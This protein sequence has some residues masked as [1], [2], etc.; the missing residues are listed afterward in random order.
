MNVEQQKEFI[1]K[2]LKSRPATIAELAKELGVSDDTIRNRMKMMIE[3]GR[4]IRVVDWR[5]LNTA[6]ARVFG[7]G[8]GPDAP[9]PVRVRIEESRPQLAVEAC[10]GKVVFRREALD[11]W[12]FRIRRATAVRKGTSDGGEHAGSATAQKR[13]SARV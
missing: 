3:E 6:M 1:E 13:T 12:M 8:T 5:V 4:P 7:Y 10:P 2:F 9:R 11:E